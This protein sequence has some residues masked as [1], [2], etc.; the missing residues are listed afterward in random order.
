MNIALI[1]EGTYPFAFGG[2]SVWCDQLIRG[3]PGYD[4]HLV[5]LV[6][7]SA[8]LAVWALPDNVVSM[9]TVP[10]W[11]PA[12]APVAGRRGGPPLRLLRQ[13]IE[14]LLDSPAGAPGR[15]GGILRELHEYSSRHGSLSTSLASDK[16]VGLLAEAWRERPVKAFYL[17]FIRHLCASTWPSMMWTSDAR[18]PASVAGWLRQGVAEVSA[19]CPVS[20]G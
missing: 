13:L 8:E 18:T 19:Q 17:R 15:F 5:A 20:P 11:G 10:L 2:V 12:P 1:T 3:M 4:F 9:S 14:F 6:A 16:A 7:T